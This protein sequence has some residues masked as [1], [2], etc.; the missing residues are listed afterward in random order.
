ME[1]IKLNYGEGVVTLPVGKAGSLRFL[2]EKAVTPIGDIKAEFLRAVGTGAIQS[3]PLEKLISAGDKVTVIISDITRFWM[4]QDIVCELLVR[5]L[6]SIGVAFD[7]IVVLAALGTHRPMSEDELKKV[8]SEYV[9]KNVRVINHDC[10]GDCVEIGTTSRGTIVKVNAL[11]TGRRVITIGGTAYHLMA[12]YGGGRKSIVPGIAARSTICQNHLHSLSPHEPCS[13]PLIGMG[14]LDNNPVGDD[15]DEAAALLEIA[16]S[17][18]IAADSH[19]SHVGLFCGSLHA[20]WL[21]SC[22]FVREMAGL[23]IDKKA[24]VVIVSCGGYPKDI[25]LY[26]GVKSLL[27]AAQALRDGGEMIFLAECREGGG[28]PA[29]FD[30]IKPLR[31]GRLDA[32]LRENFTIAGYIFYACCEAMRRFR[33]MMLTAIDAQTLA[34]M[35]ITAFNSPEKLMESV[36][37]SGKDVAVMAHGGFI[38]PYLK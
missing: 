26:Q 27:N 29:F 18:N 19:G 9:Y 37:L 22:R 11:A 5:Y 20:A 4:R 34:P 13:N 14:K 3:P 30:W 1:N 24:D 28:T 21:E 31:E 6:H 7:D 15:M 33:V 36:E 2:E 23:A 10:D 8:A 17:I 38:V 32:A 35:N 25:N 12:G 16:F